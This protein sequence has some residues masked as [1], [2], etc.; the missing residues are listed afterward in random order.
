MT[1]DT[2]DD[3]EDLNAEIDYC[4]GR[5]DEMG[6][7]HPD[8]AS[9]TVQLAELRHERW[10]E[11]GDP[12]DLDAARDLPEQVQRVTDESGEHL[13]DSEQAARARSLGLCLLSIYYRDTERSAL[14]GA[15][16][17]FERAAVLSDQD[18]SRRG[19]LMGQLGTAYLHRRAHYMP[20][21]PIELP[22]TC[23][24]E[25]I[26]LEPDAQAW[27][28]NLAL[29]HQTRYQLTPV[30]PFSPDY[31]PYANR[32]YWS[33]YGWPATSEWPDGSDSDFDS[34]WFCGLSASDYEADWPQPGT[35][36]A[37]WLDS[38]T[39]NARRPGTAGTDGLEAESDADSFESEAAPE[40]PESRRPGSRWLETETPSSHSPESAASEAD[41]L[42]SWAFVNHWVKAEPG[43]GQDDAGPGDSSSA[44]GD[45]AEENPA[46]ENA[47]DAEGARADPADENPADAEGA[48]ADPADADRSDENPADEN[49]ADEDPADEDPADENP[50]DAGR[51]DPDRINSAVTGDEPDNESPEPGP[52]QS[53]DASFCGTGLGAKVLLGPLRPPDPDPDEALLVLQGFERHRRRDDDLVRAV[54]LYS[55]ACAKCCG[56]SVSGRPRTGCNQCSS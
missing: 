11:Q 32:S 41:W 38:L 51:D 5:L 7:Y 54:E 28:H 35:P 30:D 22:L 19:W 47:A 55:A 8:W 39:A 14:D 40:W 15:I 10:S 13:D 36:D 34:G 1:F 37:D 43:A 25:A 33:G 56:G 2:D 42:D 46:E 24:Q 52:Y 49:P 26:E 23:L 6:P 4:T 44:D 12:K 20:T 21:M 50:A 31:D 48:H 3:S 16:Q 17:Q 53:I 27:L 18:D 45:L 29:C 9:L